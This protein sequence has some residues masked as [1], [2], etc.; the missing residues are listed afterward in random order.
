[1]KL[2]IKDILT[3]EQGIIVHQV[4]CRGVMGAGLALYIKQKYPQ[5]YNN[6]KK[7]C[8]MYKPE[9]LLGKVQMVKIT[10]NLVV[11]NL[12]AQLSYGRD[13]RYTDYN[14]F[15]SC[16]KKLA[17]KTDA[18][19]PIY[20]PYKIGCGLAGGDWETVYGLI[21]MYLHNHNVIICKN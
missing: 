6:Y 12:F 20:F 1:M 21:D 3:V 16:L 14:A 15:E 9:E 7:A 18:D 8:A 13:K 11:C 17:F 5:V 2:I 10:N 19:T 4:N